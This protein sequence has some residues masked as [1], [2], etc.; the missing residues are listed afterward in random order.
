MNQSKI[1]FEKPSQKNESHVKI[2]QIVKLKVPGIGS[3][4][5]V[6]KICNV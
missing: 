6:K 2:G 1:E 4:K 5:T 3:T